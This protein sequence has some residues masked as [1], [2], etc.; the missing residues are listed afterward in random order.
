MEKGIKRKGAKKKKRCTCMDKLFNN[1]NLQSNPESPYGGEMN[2]EIW[3]NGYKWIG[4][5]WLVMCNYTTTFFG[6][7][8]PKVK[9]VCPAHFWQVQITP[10]IIEC[11]QNQL[12]WENLALLPTLVRDIMANLS[13]V[14]CRQW[15][16]NLP[17][18]LLR[19]R[20][21][22]F[23]SKDGNVLLLISM[24]YKRTA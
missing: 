9:W 23:C 24:N 21:Y 1:Q 8:K 14:I 2:V 15:T 19:S 13:H 16:L 22:Q 17:C 12:S 18:T 7:F 5:E 11:T 3:L 4:V 6:L 20:L 10:I